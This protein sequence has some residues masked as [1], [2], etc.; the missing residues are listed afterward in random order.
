MTPSLVITNLP[1]TL[2]KWAKI[3]QAAGNL[4]KWLDN[5]DEARGIVSLCNEEN[6]PFSPI[7][8]DTYEELTGLGFQTVI[9]DETGFT[10]EDAVARSVNQI[11]S[12]RDESSGDILKT[13]RA[14]EIIMIV[15]GTAAGE[16]LT[17][18]LKQK[19]GQDGAND[20]IIVYLLDAIGEAK[21]K[22]AGAAILSTLQALKKHPMVAMSA[23]NA[24]GDIGYKEAK[25][26]LIELKAYYRKTFPKLDLGKLLIAVINKNLRKLEAGN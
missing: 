12:A 25:P 7:C 23:I 26:A 19:T 21:Y 20:A 16:T 17:D 3:A 9:R 8:Q 4:N 10:V 24:L 22:P 15:K 1:T 2:Q 5:E 14:I 6:G 11:I 18:L 13:Q